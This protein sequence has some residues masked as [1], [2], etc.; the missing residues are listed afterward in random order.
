MRLHA[1]AAFVVANSCAQAG[2]IL[3]SLHAFDSKDG[4]N[5]SAGLVQGSAGYFYGTTYYGGANSVGTVFKISAGGA[6]TSLASFDYTDGAYPSAGLVQGS[7][8]F[9]YG[10]TSRGGTNANGYG[11]VFQISA[12]GLLRSLNSFGRT[13][14]VFGVPFDGGVPNAPLVQAG[15]GVLYGTCSYG[16]ANDSYPG[17]TVFEISTNGAL[18]VLW[19]FTG[20]SDGS[21]PEAGLVQGRDG[22]F[23]GTTSGDFG[24]Y[25]GVFKFRPPGTVAGLDSFTGGADGG[26]PWAGLVQGSDGYFYGTTAF[27]GTYTNGTVFRM[28][29]GGALTS[30]YSFTGGNDGG[31][32]YGVLVQGSDG[33][34]YGTTALGGTY[35]N[36]TVFRISASG[37]LANLYS[38]TGGNDGGKPY[39]GLVQGSDGSFYGTTLDGG[40]NR[41]GTVFRL[42][43]GPEFQAVTFTNSTLNLTWNTEPGAL[44]QL[45]YVSDLS[46][47]NWTDLGSPFAATGA[48]LT[49]TVPITNAPE[50]FYQV[51]LLQ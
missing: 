16:G 38:F 8:G 4:A 41:Y 32:P 24:S 40:T 36:G 20:G 1:A 6:L 33:Y 11:T 42:S 37:T 50:R 9:F 39:A 22:S 45:R 29:A 17:G 19:S 13:Q 2:V 47:S 12:S 30:L 10:T 34:F 49:A 7:D 5:P 25:G 21:G 48:T 15:N 27:G 51:V 31:N 18:T 26:N 35:T 28:T 23:Y 46:L 44:Y 14:D 3:T 43:I